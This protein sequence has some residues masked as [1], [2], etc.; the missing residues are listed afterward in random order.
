MYADVRLV[1]GADQV[2]SRGRPR[3][4]YPTA[5]ADREARPD[6]VIGTAVRCGAD[7]GNAPAIA[8]H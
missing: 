4:P 7:T 8:E 3:Q 5:F 6:S 1:T 2:S